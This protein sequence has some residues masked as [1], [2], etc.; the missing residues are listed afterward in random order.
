MFSAYNLGPYSTYYEDTAMDALVQTDHSGIVYATINAAHIS[1]NEPSYNQSLYNKANNVGANLWLQLRVYDNG[2]GFNSLNLIQANPWARN[3][4]L[5]LFDAAVTQ[6]AS[7]FTGDCKIIL[8]EEAGIYHQPWTG[9]EFWAGGNQNYTGAKLSP[10]ELWDRVFVYRFSKLFNQLYARIKTLSNCDVGFHIGHAALYREY[11]GKTVMEHIFDQISTDFVMYDLYPMASTSY[12]S[13]EQ[14]L[15][16]RITLL[17]Q[18]TD[19]YYLNQMHTMNYFQN[20][21]ARAPSGKIMR[22]STE[23]AYALGAA[24]VGWYGKNALSAQNGIAFDPNAVGQTTVLE[25]SP[26]RYFYALGLTSR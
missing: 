22:D 21:G 7:A 17:A 20:G 3:Q 2:F 9:G 19:V 8:F 1:F 10:A 5:P 26:H 24:D 14:K 23:L 15:I 25:S 18:Y 13:F 6:Y 16:D 11:G 4:F 12:A